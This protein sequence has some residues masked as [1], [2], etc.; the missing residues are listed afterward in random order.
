AATGITDVNLELRAGEI[1]GLSGLVG[2]GRTE[3]A[4]T[5]FGL[6]PADEGKIL[7][8][9]KLVN[10]DSPAQAIGLGIAYLP[11]DRRRHGIILEMSISANMTLASLDQL[12]R[13][14]A[15]DFRR[16]KEI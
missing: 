5:V 1:V 15:L 2:A 16:E 4:Q 8:R 3:L 14:G 9:G 10:I 11:E 7:L 13:F 6:T 12:S